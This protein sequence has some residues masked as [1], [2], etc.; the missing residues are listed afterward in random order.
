M[1]GYEQFHQIK[2]LQARGLSA[3]RIAQQ[4]DI[5]EKTVRVWM[6]RESYTMN[7]GTQPRAKKLDAYKDH[8]TRLL[9]ECDSYSAT[10]LFD[11]LRRDGYEGS[12]TGCTK[13]LF[14]RRAKPLRSISAN[15]V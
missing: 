9:V 11:K 8:I 5:S 1:I 13:T 10:Q 4:T 2:A 6:G 14:S 12:Y 3:G 15:V 7:R